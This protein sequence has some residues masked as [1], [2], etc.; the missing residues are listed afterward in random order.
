LLCQGGGPAAA[1]VD[2]GKAGGDTSSA[3]GKGGK[4][5]PKPKPDPKHGDGEGIGDEDGGDGEFAIENAKSSRSACKSCGE[6]ITKGEVR[7]STM[8]ASDNARFRGK[9]P[10]W[11]HAKCFLTMGVWTSTLAT[12][13]GWDSL[14]AEDQTT[15]KALLKPSSKNSIPASQG[16]KRKEAPKE[17]PVQDSQTKPARPSKAADKVTNNGAEDK[18][19]KRQ[20]KEDGEAKVNSAAVDKKPIDKKQAKGKEVVPASREAIELDK[21]LEKQSKDMWELKD[22]LHQ[23]VSTAELREMLIANNQDASGSEYDLRDRW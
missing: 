8:V 6:K 17:S 12:M 20:K 19:K 11:R 9:V 3:K 16:S 22:N 4:A 18:P 7:I 10:A 1:D 23:H 5:K 14:S 21:K 2:E 13:P 15:V